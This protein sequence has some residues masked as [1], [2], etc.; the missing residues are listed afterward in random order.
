MSYIV[1]ERGLGL[2]CDE[3]DEELAAQLE[4]ERTLA[5]KQARADAVAA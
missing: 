2:L 1:K 3:F 5:E 4:S